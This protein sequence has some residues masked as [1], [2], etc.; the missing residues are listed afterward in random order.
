M[1]KATITGASGF[2]GRALVDACA[3]AGVAVRA[4]SRQPGSVR[5]GVE[6]LL[7]EDYACLPEP[8]DG[9]EM[10]F[11]LAQPSRAPAA[12]DVRE[13]VH[14]MKRL[15]TLGYS[16]MVYASSAR[17]YGDQVA[18]PRREDEAVTAI[19]HYEEMKLTCEAVADGAQGISA[20]LANLYGATQSAE[21]VIGRILA[22][23]PGSGDLKLWTMTPVRDFCWVDDCAKA[24]LAL[25]AI[26]ARGIFN[27]GTG[28]GTPIG[29]L[30]RLA[31]DTAGET[32]R[33]IWEE[34]PG[35]PA[36]TLVLDIDR[37]SETADWEPVT[38]LT[39]GLKI[40]LAKRLSI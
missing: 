30:A 36:S 17:V 13:A 3:E 14:V 4:V 29:T 12:Q 20:R 16:R 10:L 21:T 11:H 28:I 2:L 39:Q 5:P 18:F 15:A 32:V 6:T 31:L 8:R 23:I 37:I 26:N 27:V 40:A 34:S 19:G 7:L 35:A 38:S 24:M 9:G 33:H 22:Q 25:A 1:V